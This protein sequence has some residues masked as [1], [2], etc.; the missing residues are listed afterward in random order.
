[1]GRGPSN[2]AYAN[3]MF[4]LSFYLF[5]FLPPAKQAHLV[6]AKKKGRDHMFIHSQIF[7]TNTTKIWNT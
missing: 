6:A 5:L 7:D 4:L 1:M 3:L 2:A